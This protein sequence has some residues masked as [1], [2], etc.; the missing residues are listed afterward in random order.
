MEELSSRKAATGSFSCRFFLFSPRTPP[1]HSLFP[2]ISQDPEIPPTPKIAQN[3]PSLEFSPFLG[4]VGPV[5][6]FDG[7]KIEIWPNVR[8]YIWKFSWGISHCYSHID[9][10]S[11]NLLIYIF[12]SYHQKYG[13]KL[14]EKI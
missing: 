12:P 1:C 5:F 6:I 13:G 3:G 8:F 10:D 14:N 7:L 9:S 2:D 11:F 4:W